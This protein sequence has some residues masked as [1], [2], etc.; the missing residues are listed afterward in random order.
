MNKLS[1]LGS[2]SRERLSRILRVS[3]GVFTTG[4]VSEELKIS[5]AEA[6]KLLSFWNRKGWVYR[7]KRGLYIPVPLES[8]T[9]EPAVEDPWVL[10]DY[11][12]NP[13]YIGGGGGGG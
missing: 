6:S 13:C 1:G 11:L 4:L 8:S 3:R 5:G 10:A 12:F 7:I 2:I 9:N